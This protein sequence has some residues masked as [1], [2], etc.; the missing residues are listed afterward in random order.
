MIM[1]ELEQR[2]L[3]RLGNRIQRVYTYYLKKKKKRY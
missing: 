2:D 3:F 1:W